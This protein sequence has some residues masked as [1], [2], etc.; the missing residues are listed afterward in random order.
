MIKGTAGEWMDGDLFGLRLCTYAY[1]YNPY[2]TQRTFCQNK[3]EIEGG[4]QLCPPTLVTPP[5]NLLI[6]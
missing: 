6:R 2:R 4:D 3:E 5:Q 1:T